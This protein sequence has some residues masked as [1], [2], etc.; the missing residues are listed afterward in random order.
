MAELLP[1]IC[2]LSTFIPMFR[3]EEAAWRRGA[4]MVGQ[5][6]FHPPCT[7]LYYRKQLSPARSS[8]RTKMV[9]RPSFSRSTFRPESEIQA[10]P[11]AHPEIER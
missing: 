8:M 9:D 1:L 6:Y 4:Q 7:S 11:C 10:R 5:F 2:W 3:H